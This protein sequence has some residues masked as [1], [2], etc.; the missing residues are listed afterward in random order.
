MSL[1]Y[2]YKSRQKKVGWSK[3]LN[4]EEKQFYHI[5]P[6]KPTKSSEKVLNKQSTD[7]NSGTIT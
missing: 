3:R 5:D 4:D 1:I 6:R 7:K 2:N